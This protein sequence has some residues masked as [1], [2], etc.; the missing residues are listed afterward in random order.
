MEAFALPDG[1][2]KSTIGCYDGKAYERTLD[3]VKNKNSINKNT[4]KKGLLEL[5]K[6][7]P[8]L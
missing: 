2:L 8:M 3:W 7:K 5:K 6:V 1:V 4:V